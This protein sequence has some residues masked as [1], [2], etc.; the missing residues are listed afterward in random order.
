[1]VEGGEIKS[2]KDVVAGDMVLS[3]DNSG[4]HVFSEVITFLDR[5]FHSPARFLNIQLED[6]SSL[7]V[8]PNHLLF[9]ISSQ[10]YTKQ[11]TYSHS[12]ETFAGDL[13]VG[14]VL[15]TTSNSTTA[16]RISEITELTQNGFIAPL[17]ENGMI[18]V[19]GV[20]S[21]CYANYNSHFWS[22]VSM[23][24]LRIYHSFARLF[25]VSRCPDIFGIHPY[26]QVLFDAASSFSLIH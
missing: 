8:T 19:D 24:P 23:L 4:N 20:V 1:M 16:S 13:K 5:D 15:F 11:S 25:S 26:A 3:V 2:L 10:H 18:V 17:T 9:S 14:D 12:S 6:G 22:H 21:S 7:T